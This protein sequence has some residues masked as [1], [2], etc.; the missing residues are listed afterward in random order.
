VKCVESAIH[1]DALQLDWQG[2]VITLDAAAAAY[3]GTPT[4][5]GL[6]RVALPHMLVI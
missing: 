6:E 3:R 5:G 4:W 2:L 1:A